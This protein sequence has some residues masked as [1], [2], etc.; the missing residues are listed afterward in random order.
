MCHSAA[1]T[2]FTNRKVIESHHF[3]AHGHSKLKLSNSNASACVEFWHSD[4]LT[5]SQFILAL[6]FELLAHRNWV[7]P[8]MEMFGIEM[9]PLFCHDFGVVP[10]AT[11]STP[12]PSCPGRSSVAPAFTK[13]ST[14]SKKPPGGGE[15]WTQNPLI[16]LNPGWFIGAKRRAAHF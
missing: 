10:A 14:A 7:H 8:E 3:T 9:S 4:I 1:S 12:E 15:Q 2:P 11:C 16:P 6:L 5:P 13:I